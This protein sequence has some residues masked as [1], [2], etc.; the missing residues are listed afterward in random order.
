MPSSIESIEH[1]LRSICLKTIEE[2]ITG[3]DGGRSGEQP[4]SISVQCTVGHN[5]YLCRVESH[6]IEFLRAWN[7]QFGAATNEIYF[8][9]RRFF[10]QRDILDCLRN[11]LRTRLWR[12]VY[13][14]VLKEVVAPD[15]IGR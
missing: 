13:Q 12:P 1:E 2:Y 9:F 10:H 5:L 7:P 14:A 8:R 6:R 11:C 4:P 3:L 15:V